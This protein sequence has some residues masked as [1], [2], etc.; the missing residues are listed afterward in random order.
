MRKYQASISVGQCC[1]CKVPVE[2]LEM[3]MNLQIRSNIMQNHNPIQVRC[4][5][6]HFLFLE[7]SHAWFD[8]D[9]NRCANYRLETHLLNMHMVW[10]WHAQCDNIWAGCKL[11]ARRLLC[12][13]GIATR[14]RTLLRSCSMLSDHLWSC[15]LMQVMHL[16]VPRI[17][18]WKHFTDTPQQSTIT[19]ENWYWTSAH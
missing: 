6:F 11:A 10:I 2:I 5:A 16:H 13:S 18:W 17:V 8:F 3:G 12:L 1:L 19:G 15:L 9:L 14:S 7:F 4:A